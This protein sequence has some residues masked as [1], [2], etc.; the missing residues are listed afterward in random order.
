[1]HNND[2]ETDVFII[3]VA[4]M[5]L[6]SVFSPPMKMQFYPDIILIICKKNCPN[7]IVVLHAAEMFEP[8]LYY[9]LFAPSLY[10][11]TTKLID[12]IYHQF[13]MNIKEP[14]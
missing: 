2:E 7:V 1:M 4:F 6:G 12:N 9:T 8:L 5:V 14:I 10:I 13:R 11:C 3:K